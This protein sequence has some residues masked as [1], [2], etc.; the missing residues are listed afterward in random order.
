MLESDRLE[1]T[2]AVEYRGDWAPSIRCRPNADDDGGGGRTTPTRSGLS[3]SAHLL[4]TP[5]LNRAS[6]SCAADFKR[7]NRRQVHIGHLTFANN[8][9]SYAH[10][11]ISPPLNVLCTP[12]TCIVGPIPWG[13]S[14]PL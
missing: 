8:T 11:W 7:S 9:P 12:N 14:G 10:T 5:G 4:V 3:H 2:C 1:V 6:V 13:H